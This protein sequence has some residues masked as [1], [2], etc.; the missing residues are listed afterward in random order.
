MFE[1]LYYS[2]VRWRIHEVLSFVVFGLNALLKKK[3]VTIQHLGFQYNV[4][5]L[6]EEG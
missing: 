6:E 1:A 2:L 5:N 4:L 3:K